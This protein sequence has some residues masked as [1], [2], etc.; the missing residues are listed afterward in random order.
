MMFQID[1]T[2]LLCI[3]FFISFFIYTFLSNEAHKFLIKVLE[4][5]YTCEYNILV[6]FVLKVETHFLK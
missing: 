4:D 5:Y 1:F 6:V 2:L 3:I